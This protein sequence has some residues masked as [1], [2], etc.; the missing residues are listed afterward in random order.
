MFSDA[1]AG[2]AGVAD[3]AALRCRRVFAG[4]CGVGLSA[5]H[6][7]NGG[8]K[9]QIQAVVAQFMKIS[10]TLLLRMSALPRG[11]YVV[12]TTFSNGKLC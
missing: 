6:I 5:R 8:P 7:C 4:V 3:G 12:F 2:L 9:R 10:M 1:A 11:A